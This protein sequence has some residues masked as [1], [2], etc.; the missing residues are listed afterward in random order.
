M[1][2]LFVPIPDCHEFHE[3]CG[4]EFYRKLIQALQYTFKIYSFAHG[5]PMII[6]KNKEL[7]SKPID[8]L[9]KL[10]DSILRSMC[11]L[12]TYIVSIRFFHCFIYS[13]LLGRFDCKKIIFI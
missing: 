1:N 2:K 9:K 12:S 10:I 6:F 3:N 5:I 4:L 8:S 7:I 13:K 11:F